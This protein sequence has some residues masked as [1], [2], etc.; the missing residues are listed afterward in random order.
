MERNFDMADNTGT[1]SIA[2]RMY[3]RSPHHLINASVMA[4]TMWKSSGSAGKSK[5][6]LIQVK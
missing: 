6:L 5:L 2:S 4:E 3:K 1:L